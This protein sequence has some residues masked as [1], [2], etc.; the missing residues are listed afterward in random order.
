MRV[1]DVFR[2]NDW[3]ISEFFIF[4]CSIQFAL[5]GL[6]LLGVMGYE[7]PLVRPIVGFVYLTFVPGALLLRILR[8]HKASGTESILYI[9]GLSLAF[10][11]LTGFLLNV[12]GPCIGI[13]QPITEYYIILSTFFGVILLSAIC[14]YRDRDYADAGAF[15][16]L[17]PKTLMPALFLLLAPLIAVLSAYLVNVYN[18]NALTY[19]LLATVALVMI[20]CGFGRVIPERLYPLAIVSVAASLLFHNAF[21]TGYLWSWDVHHEYNFANMVIAGGYWDT[22]VLSYLN[23]MLSIVL[24]AP[25][26]HFVCNLELTWVFKIAYQLIFCLVPLGLYAVFR[27]QA[28]GRI[29]ILACMLFMSVVTFFTEM[30]GLTRQEIAEL[31]LVLIVMLMTDARLEGRVKAG[32]MVVCGMALVVSHY[33]LAYIYLIVFPLALALL[34]LAASA[35]RLL[36]RATKSKMPS[37]YR[38]FAAN[39]SVTLTFVGVFACFLFFWYIYTSDAS[40]LRS[41]SYLG[42]K[43]VTGVFSEFLDP[44]NVQGLSMI[45]QGASS[46]LYQVKKYLHLAF[47]GFIVIGFVLV[48]AQVIAMARKRYNFSAEYLVFA[49][50]NLLIC[51]GGIV[52]PYFASS[53]NTSRLYQITLIVLA[54]LCVIGGLALITAAMSPLKRHGLDIGEAAMKALTLVIVVYLFFNAGL[55]YNLTGDRPMSVSLSK[56]QI[57]TYSLNDRAGLYDPLNTFE[58]DYYAA[59]W[60]SEHRLYGLPVYSDYIAHYPISSY[61]NTTIANERY[62][63]GNLSNIGSDAYVYLG[64]PN[65]KGDVFREISGNKSI[66]HT[67]QLLPGLEDRNKVYASDGSLIYFVP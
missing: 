24:L 31:Y 5:L 6:A 58:Q 57:N 26:Y 22:S 46:P 28:G 32:L 65:L 63:N 53:L 29:A 48:A 61:G 44:D 41:I 38:A 60:L 17:D 51:I 12:L 37:V 39:H 7:V 15:L 43:M 50:I 11:M 59:S 66:Y 13:Y 8:V 27:K 34:M 18:V 2:I 47:Q 45:M 54:P 35:A 55:V 14:Y 9:A 1:K 67:S 40:A 16:E 49:F 21:V 36:D 30:Q 25:F 3:K 42:Y 64:Y 23:S 62:L 52:M 10:D 56:G 20:L 33:G 19:V 4:I